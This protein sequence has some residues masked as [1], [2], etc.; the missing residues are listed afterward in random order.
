MALDNVLVPTASAWLPKLRE[1]FK[2]IATRH[3]SPKDDVADA[4]LYGL[5]VVGRWIRGGFVVN[6]AEWGRQGLFFAKPAEHGTWGFGSEGISR[7]RSRYQFSTDREM[8]CSW[9]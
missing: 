9:D 6:N 4:C 2:A 8:P 3:G 7:E 1:Q 5:E